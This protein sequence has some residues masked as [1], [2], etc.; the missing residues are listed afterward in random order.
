MP[1]NSRNQRNNPYMV[2]GWA[3]D[4]HRVQGRHRLA[5]AHRTDPHRR[6]LAGYF[7]LAAAIT[8]LWALI[9]L[10]A[11]VTAALAVPHSRRY[12]SGTPGA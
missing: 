6:H 3:V 4:F 9:V 5:L 7:R 10:A 11:L 2:E 1:K 8:A 12:P